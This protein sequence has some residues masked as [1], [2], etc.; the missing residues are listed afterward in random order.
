MEWISPG[1][2]A[3]NQ[4][5]SLINTWRGFNANCCDRVDFPAPIL[6]ALHCRRA[7]PVGS[8]ALYAGGMAMHSS[9]SIIRIPHGKAG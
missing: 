5:S 7:L 8:A 2:S 3:A 6:R 1:Y 9:A 4:A